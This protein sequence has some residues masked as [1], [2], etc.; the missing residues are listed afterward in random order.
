MSK[1]ISV[2]ER[3]PS[4][5][6][7]VLIYGFNGLG[8]IIMVAHMNR[9]RWFFENERYEHGDFQVDFWMPLPP[10]P[11]RVTFSKIDESKPAKVKLPADTP[12]GFVWRE[13]NLDGLND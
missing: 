1:W 12:D 4:R 7:E 13:V 6:Q 9:D 8:D 10:P 11:G 5:Y 3:L 2:E